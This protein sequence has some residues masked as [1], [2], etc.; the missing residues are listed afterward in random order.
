MDKTKNLGIT[1]KNQTMMERKNEHITD[2]IFDPKADGESAK[3]LLKLL[4]AEEMKERDKILK[5]KSLSKDNA[6]STAQSKASK[7]E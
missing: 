4:L 2:F 5:Q 1:K 6:Q 7:T 3:D